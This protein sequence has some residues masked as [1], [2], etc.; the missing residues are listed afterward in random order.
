MDR[1]QTF[2]SLLRIPQRL[3]AEGSALLA[4][5][6]EQYPYFQGAQL[7][8][9]ANAET[10]Y[11][12]EAEAKR[13]EAALLLPDSFALFR[14]LDALRLY[15]LRHPST[16]AVPQETP[17]ASQESVAAELATP[18]EAETP[19]VAKPAPLPLIP[20]HSSVEDSPFPELESDI[21]LTGVLTTSLQ[22]A[23]PLPTATIYTLES[24]ED[25]DIEALYHF[26]T[27]T[28]NPNYVPPEP[29]AED[30]NAMPDTEWQPVSPELQMALINSFLKNL[31]GENGI[32]AT[33]L[34]KAEEAE[35]EGRL[36]EDLGQ[37]SEHVANSSSME[38]VA[39]I[40]E[41]RGEL[42]KA[43]EVYE[44]LIH[45]F[46]KK[47]AYFATEIQRLEALVAPQSNE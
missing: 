28:L 7:L 8:T 1:V 3:S 9:A 15:E 4:A 18:L 34:R 31:D 22:T 12:Q 35:R 19:Q 47:S 26:V 36:L 46:P 6:Q 10:L 27:T 43:I 40:Y 2:Y 14:Y 29:A 44:Q 41:T 5:L 17:Q 20:P 39:Q 21:D 11:P 13:A 24:D 32:K 37:A 25:V 30:E 45:D 16:V 42:A 33:V 23:Y 38:R